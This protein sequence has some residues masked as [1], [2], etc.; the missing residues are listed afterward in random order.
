MM[1]GNNGIGTSMMPSKKGIAQLWRASKL[2]AAVALMI[3]H[4]LKGIRS[5][6]LEATVNIAH[7]QQLE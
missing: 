6:D 7:A 5:T 4:S 2:M 3:D 1:K